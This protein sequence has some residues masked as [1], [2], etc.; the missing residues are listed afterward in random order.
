MLFIAIGITVL[1]FIGGAFVLDCRRR[2][3]A[4]DTLAV[5]IRDSQV[6]ACSECGGSGEVE[7]HE[8]CWPHCPTGETAPCPY[9]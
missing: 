1:A 5:I 3:S 6:R 9:C 4:A 2:K 8:D 7:L